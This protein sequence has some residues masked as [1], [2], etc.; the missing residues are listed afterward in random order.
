[1]KLT[2]AGIDPSAFDWGHSFFGSIYPDRAALARAAA[3][4]V[5]SG[6]LVGDSGGDGVAANAGGFGFVAVTTGGLAPEDFA[7]FDPA[8]VV[9][10]W[11]AQLDDFVATV[12][13]LA[14]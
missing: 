4:A 12:A 11:A 8:L 9:T 7:N 13:R 10:D 3:R 2:S 14:G 6:V 1:V 5:S